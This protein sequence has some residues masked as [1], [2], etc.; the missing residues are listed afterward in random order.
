VGWRF[1]PRCTIPSRSETKYAPAKK[2]I[3]KEMKAVF[4]RPAQNKVIALR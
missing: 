4:A 3:P 1:I 2:I